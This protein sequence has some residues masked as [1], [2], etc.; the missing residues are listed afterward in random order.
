MSA[1]A[2]ASDAN[3]ALLRI[4]RFMCSSTSAGIDV[5]AVENAPARRVKKGKRPGGGAVRAVRS[6]RNGP[7]S[8]TW[9]RPASDVSSPP[10]RV[11]GLVAAVGAAE[12]IEPR[13]DRGREDERGAQAEPVGGAEPVGRRDEA[14]DGQEIKKH[15][16][17]AEGRGGAL[18]PGRAVWCEGP[19]ECEPR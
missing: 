2:P 16:R 3:V 1:K 7:I 10:A 15:R 17:P 18:T 8:A 12:R 14:G 5:G 13:D 11:C 6:R 9:P 19:G 4:H